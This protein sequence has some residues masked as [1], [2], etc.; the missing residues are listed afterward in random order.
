MG[1]TID[2]DVLA[3]NYFIRFIIVFESDAVQKAFVEQA[4]S[5][6]SEW[7]WLVIHENDRPGQDVP[8]K[9]CRVENIEDCVLSIEK[10]IH[11]FFYKTTS[12]IYTMANTLFHHSL[13][14]I[15]TVPMT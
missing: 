11:S 7:S 3:D 13:F 10:T 8:E 15:E 4:E 2:F 1:L 12:E 5:S 9:I 14:T 6:I